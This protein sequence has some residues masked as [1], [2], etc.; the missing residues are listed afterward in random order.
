MAYVQTDVP[1]NAY[2][3]PVQQ[4]TTTTTYVQQPTY[5]APM[6]QPTTTTI[7]VTQEKSSSD[8]STSWILFIVGFFTLGCLL[9][10]PGAWIGLRSQDKDARLPGILNA[11]FTGIGCVSGIIVIIYVAVATSQLA[12]G[13]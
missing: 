9:W 5:V 1:Y 8:V 13:A 7:I 2:G 6:G 12:S 10:I 4:Q 3:A 11:V